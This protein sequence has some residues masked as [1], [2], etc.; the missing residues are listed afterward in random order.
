MINRTLIVIIIGVLTLSYI[1]QLFAEDKQMTDEDFVK[2]YVKL[3]VI[4]EK[5]LTDSLSLKEKQDKIF[6]EMN[7]T[8]KQFDNYIYSLDEDPERWAAIWDEIEKQLKNISNDSL[9]TEQ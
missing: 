2:L 8:K 5:N 4:A 7:Y 6:S 3:A 9:S 1:G